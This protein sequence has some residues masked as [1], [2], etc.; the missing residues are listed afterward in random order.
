M[1]LRIGDEAPN[2]TAQTTDGSIDLHQ[3]MPEV[4][5][6]CL[7]STPRCLDSKAGSALTP[8]TGPS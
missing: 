5:Y 7:D 6:T 2:F 1:S 3:W 8:E 4:G